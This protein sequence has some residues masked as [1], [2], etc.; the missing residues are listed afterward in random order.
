MSK[1]F[2]DLPEL[3]NEGARGSSLLER[4]YREIGLAA[5]AAELEVSLDDLSE[6]FAADANDQGR[7]LAA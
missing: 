4:L 3:S 5:I 2:A 1:D 7:E 6:S